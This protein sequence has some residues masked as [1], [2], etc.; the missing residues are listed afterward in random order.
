MGK[1]TE[2]LSHILKPLLVSAVIAFVPVAA[3]AQ[4]AIDVVYTQ[5]DLAFVE[6]SSENVANILEKYS[7]SKDYSYYESYVLKKA[8]Q[9]VIENKLEFA[10]DA[11]LSVIDNNLEN[12]DAVDLYSYIDRAIL[13]EEA[14]RQ[15]EENRLRLEAERL[16]AIT[17]RT[18]TKLAKSE[19]YSSVST[20]SGTSVYLS[21]DK[22]FSHTDWNVS[23][24][25]ADFLYQMVT[26][27]ESYTSL[28]YGLCFNADFFYQTEEYIAGGNIFADFE[29]LTLG[30]GEQEI[31]TSVKLIPMLAFPGFSK[32]LFLRF[33]FA[34]H[35]LNATTEVETGTVDTF[36]TPAFGLGLFNIPVGGSAFNMYY[37]YYL[38]HLAYKSIQTS[39]E[40]GA[41]I[42]LPVATNEKTKI[43]FKIGVIDTLFVKD[44]GIDNRARGIISIGVGNVK[45]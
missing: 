17:E 24:G 11:T 13:N 43:G 40:A 39:M 27:P 15:A 2:K 32:N 42:M 25:I 44:E 7:S 22:S 5:I 23:V 28:K 10:R 3:G 41:S 6:Q 26:K 34:A 38:G 20:A 30:D 4:D 16:A 19:T 29:M 9:A 12:F 36:F 35:G 33:G 45:N 1:S 8:R 14:A 21:Q 18:K 37:D 31:L